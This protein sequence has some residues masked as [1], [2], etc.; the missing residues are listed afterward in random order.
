MDGEAWLSLVERCVRDAE[1]ACSNHVASMKLKYRRIC[2]KDRPVFFVYKSI[3]RPVFLIQIINLFSSPYISQDV[4]ISQ[5][6]ILPYPI[7]R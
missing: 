2:K 3:Y 1:V 4:I 5:Q 6:Y 7:V